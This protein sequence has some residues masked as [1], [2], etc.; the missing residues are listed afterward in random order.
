[1]SAGS[2]V[3]QDPGLEVPDRGPVPGIA[4]GEQ[5]PLHRD[6]GVA[7]QEGDE[8]APFDLAREHGG[9]RD[10]H[11]EALDRGLDDHAVDAEAGGSGSPLPPSLTGSA[12]SRAISVHRSSSGG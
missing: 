12:C 3:L 9:G 2:G 6:L 10:S 4:G 8:D 7:V 5:A 11:A 1:M